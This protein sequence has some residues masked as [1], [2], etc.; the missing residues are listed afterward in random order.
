[1][2]DKWKCSALK[3][4]SIWLVTAARVWLA[5]GR[6]CESKATYFQLQGALEKRCAP[7]RPLSARLSGLYLLLLGY[8]FVIVFWKPEFSAKVLK[9]VA[10]HVAFFI[11]CL[12][13]SSINWKSTSSFCGC[14]ETH[15]DSRRE[16]GLHEMA[17]MCVNT[18][19]HSDVMFDLN[20]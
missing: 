16:H 19:Y 5:L 9:R 8:H 2:A 6:R 10:L 11:L 14:F 20:L 15:L 18:V 1:M 17:E 7:T 12:F 13:W 4:S 3:N